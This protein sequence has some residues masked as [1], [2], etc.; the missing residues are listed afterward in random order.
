MQIN[1]FDGKKINV[2]VWDEVSSPVGVVQIFH[3]MS[4]H[5]GRYERYA[6]ELNE[7]GYVVY[8]SDHRGHGYT[9]GDTLGYSKG[10]MFS[11]T[12]KDCAEIAKRIKERY[13][14]LKLLLFAHSYGSFLA[15]KFISLYPDIYDG[16]VMYGSS[17]KKDLEVY[18]GL[19]VSFLGKIFTGGKRQAKLIEK[20]SFGAYS[21]KFADRLWL[22]VDLPF[23]RSYY[24]DKLCAF[25]CSNNFYFSFFKGLTSLYTKKYAKSLNKNLP[26]LIISGENDA[27][28]NMGRGVK[29][30]YNYYKK[31][32]MNNVSMHLIKNS[33][34]VCLYEEVNRA[35]FLSK[36]DEFFEGII[37][38][39]ED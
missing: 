31:M 29:K 26:V 21:S 39:K 24:S 18:M 5:S 20:L 36:T 9:D 3:G 23:N 15:Q 37:N 13:P 14:S 17:H 38:R 7:R 8:A 25:T 16:V 35:E 22:S 2:R 34:H 4:E 11:D 6:K 32:G 28:G 1:S 30:L 10:D 19:A 33:R 27:V 12:L